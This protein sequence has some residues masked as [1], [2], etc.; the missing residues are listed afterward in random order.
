MNS[1]NTHVTNAGC[2]SIALCNLLLLSLSE[3]CSIPKVDHARCWVFGSNSVKSHC[4]DMV[5][6]G[7]V[8]YECKYGNPLRG[9]RSRVCDIEQGKLL[10]ESPV[11]PGKFRRQFDISKMVL[12]VVCARLFEAWRVFESQ[13]SGTFNTAGPCSFR[14]RFLINLHNIKEYQAM[15]GWTADNT[16]T[17]KQTLSLRNK[18]PIDILPAPGFI[19]S[20]SNLQVADWNWIKFSSLCLFQIHFPESCPGMP[21]PKPPHNH[22]IPLQSP[23]QCAETVRLPSS[24]LRTPRTDVRKMLYT[25]VSLSMIKG[26]VSRYSV[27]VCTFSSMPKNGDCSRKC[28]GHSIMTARSVARTTS[29]PKLSPANVVFRGLALRLPLFFPTQNGCQKWPIIVTLPL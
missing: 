7:Q 13:Q 6:R 20:A 4:D 2:L 14:G 5:G 22:T 9:H 29:S 10:G 25:F 28:R 23:G 16:I 24:P 1:Q 11:C 26:A 8:Q 15:P 17:L 3:P 27:I 18:D 21:L 19:Q 12:W